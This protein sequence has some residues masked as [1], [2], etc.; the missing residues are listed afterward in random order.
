MVGICAAIILLSIALVSLLFLYGCADTCTVSILAILSA[1][2]MQIRLG[3]IVFQSNCNYSLVKNIDEGRFYNEPIQLTATNWP[4]SNDFVTDFVAVI[5]S[6]SEGLGKMALG[7]SKNIFWICPSQPIGVVRG[8]LSWIRFIKA[9]SRKF[10][11]STACKISIGFTSE[12][13]VSRNFSL[14]YFAYFS[15]KKEKL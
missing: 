12:V 8:Q 13:F 6:Q 3:M 9:S 11:S 7:D 2:A 5:S 15:K 1:S 14:K 10:Y 4:R